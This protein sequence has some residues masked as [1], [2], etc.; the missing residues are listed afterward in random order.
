MAT[1]KDVASKAGVS[2]ATASRALSGAG[3][4]SDEVR[5]RVLEAAAVLE[6][7]V[8]KAARSL[9]THR[10]DT[11]G[12]LISDVRNPFFS[13]VAYTIEQEAAQQG[14][15]VI[16]MS[17]DE[18]VDG[19]HRALH[20]LLRQGVDGLIVVPQRG[21]I[22]H[23]SFD[24]PMVF[25]DRSVDGLQVPT[26]QSDNKHGMRTLVDHLVHL[27]HREIALILGPQ[28]ASSGRE[29]Y[30]GAIQ[31]L[32]AHGLEPRPEWIQP[33]DFKLESGK[34]A[35]AA[36]LTAKHRPSA[37][38]AGDNLMAVGALLEARERGIQIGYDVALVSFDDAPWFPVLDPPLTVVAQDTRALGECALTRL[39]DL[40]AGQDTTSATIPTQLIIRE[41]C[42]IAGTPAGRS[43]L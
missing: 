27:G 41:S 38:I 32:A 15:A 22:S 34:L 8:N 24:T 6:Y 29:R 18:S 37:I 4:V 33:G 3:P 2:M 13:E 20:A 17:A 23:F 7:R 30:E 36:L 19:Q 10:T 25:L 42:R 5:Q 40:I 28:E 31:A 35:V 16:V 26:V 12:L 39:N 11:I 14:Q 1:I 21:T 43:R 9:R